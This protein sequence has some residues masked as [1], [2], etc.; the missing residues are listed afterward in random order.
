M[1]LSKKMLE[2]GWNIIREN[3]NAYTVIGSGNRKYTFCPETGEW[4][5]PL[6]KIEESLQNDHQEIQKG[7]LSAAVTV[8]RLT[9][10]IHTRNSSQ[11][12]QFLCKQG[13]VKNKTVLH[14]GTGRDDLAKKDL[15]Q[16]GCKSVADYD[17]NYYPDREVLS[18][19]YDVVIANY[20]LNI[21]PPQE[22]REVYGLLSDTLGDK[23]VAYLTVQGVWPVEN[24]YK[25][26]GECHDG[27][28]I[29]A[30]FNETFRKGYTP[31]GFIKEI[32]NEIG[33]SPELIKMFYS[34]SFVKWTR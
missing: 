8:S 17:P 2:A 30:G 18:D 20:V 34:N 16:S 3:N 13:L 22:R 27:Y 32:K 24:K 12:I 9:A 19:K 25:I 28:L 33:G 21:L 26:T 6:E 11:P 14:L 5:A 10:L 15:M 23:G 4:S 7:N 29:Q 1:K 31:E